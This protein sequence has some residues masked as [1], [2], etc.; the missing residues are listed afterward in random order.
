MKNTN[1][2]IVAIA[3]IGNSFL[4]RAQVPGTIDTDFGT[5]GYLL[6]DHVAQY[7]ENFLDMTVLPDN[8]FILIG[9]VGGDNEDILLAKYDADG[10]PADGFGN[11]GVAQLDLSLGGYDLGFVVVPLS[12]GKLLIGGSTEVK[13]GNSGFVTRLNADGSIDN[14]FGEGG[15][16][17]TLLNAGNGSQA[18]VT[19]IVVQP[20]NNILALAAVEGDNGNMDIAVFKLTAGGGIVESFASSG[21]SLID[22]GGFNSDDIAEDLDLLPDGRMVIGG[23]SDSDI[24]VGFVM[25]L[26][27]YG[28]IENSFNLTGYYLYN[29]LQMDQRVLAVNASTG[30]IFATGYTASGTN[31]DGFVLCLDTYGTPDDAFGTDGVV[32]SDIGTDNGIILQNIVMLEENKILLT[33]HTSG[34]SINGPYALLLT[35]SGSPDA[36]FAPGGSIYPEL[37]LNIAYLS[38]TVAG[39]QSDG[40][41]LLGGY[42]AS[43]DFQGDNMYMMRIF[44]P[45]SASGTTDQPANAAMVHCY[46]NPATQYFRIE[47][48][49]EKLISVSLYSAQGQLINCWKGNPGNFYLPEQMSEGVHVLVIETEQHVFSSSLVIAP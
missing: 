28:L 12:D 46:P 38:G 14:S 48:G 22:L 16:G 11:M 20:D 23:H 40:R 31:S 17:T 29:L 34:V 42:L 2:L 19:D 8:S 26:N 39:V 37:G 36:D 45:E 44:G 49:D 43:E 3:L 21:V 33:G 27:T 5:N 41:I 15:T 13:S 30:K 9:V 18:T 35:A 10:T 7:G 32:T 47:T 6:T 25:L 24:R 4:L 1:Y